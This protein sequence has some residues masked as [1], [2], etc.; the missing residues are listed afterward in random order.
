MD[1]T[2][3]RPFRD[4]DIE[5]VVDL[6]LRAW[7]PVFSSFGTVL[8]D[9]LYQ[10][11]YPDWRTQQAEAV[12]QALDDNETWVSVASDTVV[13]FV[14]LIVDS[15]EGAGEIYMI[16]VDPD[17]QQRGIASDLTEFALTEMRRQGLT[18]ATVATGGDP[19]HLPA[20]R[21]YEKVGF[22]PFPQVLYTK[23]LGSDDGDRPG[24]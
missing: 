22:T 24:S 4:A 9:D 13:G 21:T 1:S 20:R 5:A 18:L 16:A 12:R 7:T 10:R 14:N 8:G 23:L 3:L 2:S 6:S 19:G 17:F 11:I 15:D